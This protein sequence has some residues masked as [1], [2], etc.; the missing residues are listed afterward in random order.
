MRNPPAVVPYPK[1][2][3]NVLAAGTPDAGH[4]GLRAKWVSG[5][6]A[7][8]GS[9][10]TMTMRPSAN[11]AAS[12]LL[13]FVATVS[14][15]SPPGILKFASA[16]DWLLSCSFRCPYQMYASLLDVGLAN[17]PSSPV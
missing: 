11:D 15:G 5:K 4:R 17:V 13:G 2:V 12:R 10:M 3:R 16:Y 9:R 7:M 14:V 8:I 6:A 1:G